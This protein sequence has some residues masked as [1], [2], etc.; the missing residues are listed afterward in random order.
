MAFLFTIE[1]NIARPHAETLLTSPFKEIWK[2]DKSKDKSL[3]LKE[4]SFIEFMMSKKK[5]NPFSQYEPE[6]RLKEVTHMLFKDEDWVPDE[7][8]QEGMK[9]LHD[10]QT[11][12]STAYSF[13]LA[14]E[15]A[16]EKI[17]KFFLNIDLNERTKSG[18]SVFKVKEITS[19]FNDISDNLKNL[20]A[21][22]EMVEQELYESSKIRNN[23][24]INP[25][26]M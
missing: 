17:K 11:E 1:K 12:G 16:L 5:T 25:F 20:H 6:V 4:F 14:A 26:E 3:A 24:E 10:F 18:N 21:A 19:A 9:K 8:V 13:L 2:R 7:L 23:R 22:R 15:T